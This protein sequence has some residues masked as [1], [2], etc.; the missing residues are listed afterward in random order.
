MNMGLFKDEITQDGFGGCSDAEA[1]EL[2]SYYTY[3]NMKA[4]QST[5]GIER[6]NWIMN[7]APEYAS[8]L[9]EQQMFLTQ[10][11]QPGVQA[12]PQLLYSMG[13]IRT[14]SSI[15]DLQSKFVPPTNFNAAERRFNVL[16]NSETDDA[17]RDSK[18]I[19]F[20]YDKSGQYY[21]SVINITEKPLK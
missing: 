12:N 15:G 21:N 11:G 5:I 6:W 9:M 8:T 13:L 18:L 3:Q 20:M 19:Q 14:P 2:F 7:N 4:V 1:R 16:T 17:D 10:N